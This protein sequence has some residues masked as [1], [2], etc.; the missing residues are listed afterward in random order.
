MIE[1]SYFAQKLILRNE[2]KWKVQEVKEYNSP[3]TFQ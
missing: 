1:N 3:N 2:I